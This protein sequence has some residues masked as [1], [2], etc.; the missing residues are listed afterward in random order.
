MKPVK[1]IVYL[2]IAFTWSWVSWFIG[3][4]YLAGGINRTSVGH[5]VNCFF[6]GVYGP[7]IGSLVS[8]LLFDGFRGVAVLFNRLIR[9]RAPIAVYLLIILLPI[10]VLVTAIGLFSIYYDKIGAINFAAVAGIPMLLLRASVAGPLGEELGWRGLLL[11]EL[12]KK[13]SP[14]IASLIL[15]VIWYCWHIPLFF[16]PFGT[17]VSGAPLTIVPLLVYLIFVL[18]LALI[19]TWL[20]NNSNGSVLITILMHLSVN[21]GAV[22]LLFPAL[23]NDYKL[24]YLLA[25]P[26]LV[27]F[28]LWLGW[29]TRFRGE[30]TS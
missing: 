7:A 30:T 29:R 22:L 28:T 25:T 6:F 24:L 9:W 20:F 27:L 2:L 23:E 17:L 19:N 5:F 15:G 26:A 14:I 8:T 1:V 11:P 12:Q 10:F 3:L 18:C 21:A 13:Y 16:A 4:H